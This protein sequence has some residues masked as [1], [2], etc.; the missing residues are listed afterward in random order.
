M[1]VRGGEMGIPCHM[2]SVSDASRR[3]AFLADSV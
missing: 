2:R 3:V 1:S